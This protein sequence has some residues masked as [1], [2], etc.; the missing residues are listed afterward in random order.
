MLLAAALLPARLFGAGAFEL[1]DPFSGVSLGLREI[2]PATPATEAYPA[3]IFDGPTDKIYYLSP[4]QVD[5]S[6]VPTPPAAG[7]TEDEK[8]LATVRRW[9]AERTETQCAAAN[10]QAN[11]AY[12]AFFG[13]I[14]PFAAPTPKEVDKILQKVRT[15]TGSLVFLQK[16]LYRRP[17][18]FLRDP[19]ITP[20][21]DRESGYSYPSGHSTAARVF[22]LILSDL[23]PASAGKFMAYSDQAALNRVIGGVHHP[24]DIEAGKA[25]GDAIYKALKQNRSFAG[26]METL[27]RNLKH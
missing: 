13:E 22:G 18:P 12:D 19:A 21:L 11:A 6:Q 23:V 1:R 9:Q 15:D 16:Q 27:R 25:L 20:C 24:S 14:T 10:T 26:D 5:M 8:D 2:V 4:S 3:G 7:S 17:R